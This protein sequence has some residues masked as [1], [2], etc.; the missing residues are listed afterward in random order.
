MPALAAW[1][2]GTV[3]KIRLRYLPPFWREKG[4]SGMVMWRD[5][6][7]LFACDASGTAAHAALASSS[8]VRWPSNGAARPE[9]RLHAE[10]MARLPAALG[11]EAAETSIIPSATGPATPGAA[12]AT[13]TSSSIMEGD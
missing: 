9:A 13:A 5:A 10:V 6:T 8:A 12:A 2:S 3:I 4:L 7:G 11:P 1:R